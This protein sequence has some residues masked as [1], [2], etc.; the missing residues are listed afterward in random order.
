MF[1]FI[2]FIL[3]VKVCLPEPFELCLSYLGKLILA[4][5][6]DWFE[7]S[8]VLVPKSDKNFLSELDLPSA[9]SGW[10]PILKWWFYLFDWLASLADCWY[11][12]F[13]SRSIIERVWVF[14]W[15]KFGFDDWTC[16]NKFWLFFRVYRI[17]LA[18]FIITLNLK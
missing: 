2:F 6:P 8:L 5:L 3:Q 10:L 7:K 9:S 14:D 1:T 12:I 15:L 13:W 4:L 17:S 11:L 18:F 16:L